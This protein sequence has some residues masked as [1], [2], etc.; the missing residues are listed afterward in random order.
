MIGKR[1]KA[2][3]YEKDTTNQLMMRKPVSDT[4]NVVTNVL[5]SKPCS[6][7]F[8][9]ELFRRVKQLSIHLT[10]SIFES[11]GEKFSFELERDSTVFPKT[12][13]K[14]FGH[15]LG[16]LLYSRRFLKLHINII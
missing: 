6:N 14:L 2:E 3:R 5:Q 12:Y 4:T 8:Q 9:S 16:F 7:G 1:K 13:G 10:L 11:Q 15:I